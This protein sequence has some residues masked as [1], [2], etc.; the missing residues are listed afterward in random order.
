[1]T[2]APWLFPWRVLLTLPP[3]LS[4]VSILCLVWSVTFLRPSTAA[5]TAPSPTPAL[6][7][8]P[9][10]L[11]GPCLMHWTMPDENQSTLPPQG[12]LGW[13]SLATTCPSP[14]SSHVHVPTATH[15]LTG[16][17]YNAFHGVAPKTPTAPHFDTHSKGQPHGA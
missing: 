1:M 4:R 8:P 16:K 2:P 9:Q 13:R 3:S 12:L 15:I 5:N 11:Q 14:T 7:H 17:R 6:P 10:G